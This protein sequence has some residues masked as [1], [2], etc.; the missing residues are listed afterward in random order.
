MLAEGETET[1]SIFVAFKKDLACRKRVREHKQTFVSTYTW[2]VMGP[3]KD[4][5]IAVGVGKSGTTQRYTK[6]DTDHRQ[7][8]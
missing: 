7:T 1:R 5:N 3:E 6:Q 8:V 4:N 2:T